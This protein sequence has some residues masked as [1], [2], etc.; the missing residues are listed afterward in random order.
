MQNSFGSKNKFT[1]LPTRPLK[2]NAPLAK[3]NTSVSKNLFSL[4][5][6]F[7]EPPTPAQENSYSYSYHPL[8]ASTYSS[9]TTISNTTYNSSKHLK[10]S[11]TLQHGTI[12]PTLKKTTSHSNVP[13]KN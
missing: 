2:S 1:L 4:V 5:N 12:T 3:Y 6:P 13:K 10:G 7:S 11:T 9:N 8:K